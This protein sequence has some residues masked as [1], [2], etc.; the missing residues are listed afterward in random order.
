MRGPANFPGSLL[1]SLAN[2][3]EKTSDAVAPTDT[4]RTASAVP[5]YGTFHPTSIKRL[6][7]IFLRIVLYD[8]FSPLPY[9]LAFLPKTVRICPGKGLAAAA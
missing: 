7:P 2:L 5:S 1:D 6:L 9:K 8:P 3:P 4:M